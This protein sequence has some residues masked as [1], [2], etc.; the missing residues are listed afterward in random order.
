MHFL[1]THSDI[2]I[3]IYW[4]ASVLISGMPAPQST[5][6]VGYKYLFHVLH[7]FAADLSSYFSNLGVNTN[8]GGDSVKKA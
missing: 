7:V 6:S 8:S 2:T 1:L 4:V 5:S 3:P